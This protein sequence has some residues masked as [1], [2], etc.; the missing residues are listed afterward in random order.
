LRR[1]EADQYVA[2]TMGGIALDLTEVSGQVVA[3]DLRPCG[4]DRIHPGGVGR[5]GVDRAP[6]LVESIGVIRPSDQV[7]VVPVMPTT[8]V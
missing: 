3:V 4:M 7:R 2:L 5:A 6:V 8:V 1:Q